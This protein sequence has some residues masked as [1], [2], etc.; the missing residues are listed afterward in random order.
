LDIQTLIPIRIGTNS[1]FGRNIHN[2][3][4][5]CVRYENKTHNTDTVWRPVLTLTT[6]LHFMRHVHKTQHS[7]TGKA[8]VIGDG[9]THPLVDTLRVY[10]PVWRGIQLHSHIET[11]VQTVVASRRSHKQSC[12][13]TDLS[14]G[15][16]TA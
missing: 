4:C 7:N 10:V 11:L 5:V 13:T 2:E 12:A 9:G 8:L 6:V 15:H 14:E 16:I 1:R 3:L